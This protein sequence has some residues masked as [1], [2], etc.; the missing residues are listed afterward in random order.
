MSAIIK[1]ITIDPPLD[2]KENMRRDKKNLR[3][4]KTA[5]SSSYLIRIY[6]WSRPTISLGWAQSIK[7]FLNKVNPG[8]AMVKRITGGRAVLHEREITYSVTAPVPS[9]YFG[10]TLYGSYKII[11]RILVSFLQNLGIKA[12]LKRQKTAAGN[13]SPVCFATT[14]VYEIE[15]RGKKLIGSAQK[16][17]KKGFLQHGSLPL[18]CSQQKLAQYLDLSAAG[19]HHNHYLCLKDLVNDFSV[20]ELKKNLANAFEKYIN[21]KNKNQA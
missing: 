19:T 12:S 8:I 14:S 18:F 1:K 17:E 16:R 13:K 5:G 10:H 7:P 3:L 9:P 11:A 4:I 21:E 6:E 15:V 2:G 20:N